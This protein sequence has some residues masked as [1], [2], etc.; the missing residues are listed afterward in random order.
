MGTNPCVSNVSHSSACDL[1]EAIP[2][3]CP[4][5]TVTGVMVLD[6]FRHE[7]DKQLVGEMTVKP[8][9]VPS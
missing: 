4:A 5:C 6:Q 8:I 2:G 3:L 1:V 9:Q 7:K